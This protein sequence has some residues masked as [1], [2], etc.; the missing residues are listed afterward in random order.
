MSSESVKLTSRA[1]SWK[2][3]EVTKGKWLPVLSE[4]T[5]VSEILILGEKSDNSNC[6]V[7]IYCCVY[8]DESSCGFT[9]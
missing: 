2:D 8:V 3:C 6:S 9:V 4:E 1:F 7:G 5:A